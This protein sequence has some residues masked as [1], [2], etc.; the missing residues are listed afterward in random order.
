MSTIIADNL[1][2]KTAAGNVTVTS[3]G[4]AATFQLQQG[5]AKAWGD[6]ELSG[7]HAFTDS[8]NMSSITDNAVGKTTLAPTNNMSSANYGCSGITYRADTTN[9]YSTSVTIGASKTSSSIPLFVMY[10]TNFNDSPEDTHL[11]AHGDLA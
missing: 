2:G 8:F 11:I 4:G 3:E 7:T 10:T 1:T 9:A 5:L 6:F